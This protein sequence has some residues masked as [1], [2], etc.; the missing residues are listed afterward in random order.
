MILNQY[1]ISEKIYE[2]QMVLYDS[3]PEFTG[4][5]F[6]HIKIGKGRT[7]WAYVT[8]LGNNEFDLTVSKTLFEAIPN[9]YVAEHRLFECMIHEIMHTIP[10][11]L[12]HT[13]KWKQIA[14]MLNS[15]YGFNISRC[16]SSNEC[17]VV[18]PP[19]S[20]KYKI[21]CEDCGMEYKYNRRLKYPI[22]T[23]SCGKCG[24]KHLHNESVIKIGV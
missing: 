5:N 14:N 11:C 13:G 23:Y 18:L 15:K 6:K 10:G 2:A 4:I 7:S 21:V 17:D 16:N 1:I 12:S 22:N 8:K 24:G 3:V 20:Y 9:E 19:K